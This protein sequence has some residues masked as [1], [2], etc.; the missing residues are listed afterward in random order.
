MLFCGVVGFLGF[1]GGCFFV[2]LFVVVV[3]CFILF[4]LLFTFFTF[5]SNLVVGLLVSAGI[6]YHKLQTASNN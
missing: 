6:P 4:T 5:L 2:V 3:P 1:F